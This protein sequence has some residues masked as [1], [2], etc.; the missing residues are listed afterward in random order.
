[1]ADSSRNRRPA[2]GWRPGESPGFDAGRKNNSRNVRNNV[3]PQ[4]RMPE[5]PFQNAQWYDF[6]FTPALIIAAVLI[7][8]N[9]NSVMFAFARLTYIVMDFSIVALLVVAFF[10][11]IVFLLR[12]RRGRKR[13][14]L[15]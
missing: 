4:I 2:G 5:L 13:R 6:V 3:R 8:M 1:M 7:I 11:V 12:G 10:G 9:W 15:W 14:G